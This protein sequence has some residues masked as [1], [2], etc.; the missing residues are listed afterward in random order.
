MLLFDLLFY[1]IS[2]FQFHLVY[3]RTNQLLTLSDLDLTNKTKEFRDRLDKGEILDDLLVEA[4]A[5]AR[6]ATKRV[7]GMR[8]YRVQLIGG[9]VSASRSAR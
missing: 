5:V 6:E 1:L 4:F 7:L 2:L 8:Q 3:S 9:I